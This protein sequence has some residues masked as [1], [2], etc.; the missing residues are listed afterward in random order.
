MEGPR[1]FFPSSNQIFCGWTCSK[2]FS[3]V[4]AP[5]RIF[6]FKWYH[7]EVTPQTFGCNWQIFHTNNVSGQFVNISCVC[8]PNC[9]N[10]ICQ[11]FES[12]KILYRHLV[13]AKFP[14][15]NVSN[16]E[17]D[18]SLTFVDFSEF[19][20]QEQHLQKI[21]ASFFLQ[22]SRAFHAFEVCSLFSQ[23]APDAAHPFDVFRPYVY[24]IWF[25]A[26]K[27]HSSLQF[28][29]WQSAWPGCLRLVGGK[30]GFLQK[31]FLFRVTQ[32]FSDWLNIVRESCCF[33]WR[34]TMTNYRH[35]LFV[36]KFG[37]VRNFF[38]IG[39]DFSS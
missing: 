14:W 2:I 24:K 18:S 27:K 28:L 6:L 8:L 34:C 16:I 25:W 29:V 31:S 10:V 35:V 36:S 4:S 20:M 7:S 32:L 19:H 12:R 22:A 9:V 17:L 21:S 11:M 13:N 26:E 15:R 33:N 39:L 1:K 3:N 23:I 38:S 37:F 30:K 5:S